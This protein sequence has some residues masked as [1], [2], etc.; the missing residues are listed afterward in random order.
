VQV[1]VMDYLSQKNVIG[2]TVR[3]TAYFQAFLFYVLSSLTGTSNDA[4]RYY[5][6]KYCNDWRGIA[7]DVSVNT[8][9]RKF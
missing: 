6:E 7:R 4:V 8:K 3:I 1:N 9:C 5:R 2:S